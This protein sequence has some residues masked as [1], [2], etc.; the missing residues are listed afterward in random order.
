LVD[1]LSHFGTSEDDLATDKNQKHN[2]W[3]DHAVDETGEQLRF[4]RAE[5]VMLRG[6]TFETDGEL[7]IAR[8]DDVLDLEI[9]E[10][11]VEA[12]L[13]DDTCVLAR[14][15]LRVVFGLGTGHDHLARGEDESSG[16]R[17]ANAHDNSSETLSRLAITVKKHIGSDS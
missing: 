7:D 1:L 6:E 17:L 14:G 5:V 12:Q 2:T 15:K 13:L 16:L 4:V 3:L 10:L 11:G 9:G 8:A